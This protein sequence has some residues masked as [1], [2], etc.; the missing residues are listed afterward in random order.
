LLTNSTVQLAVDDQ[1]FTFSTRL[2]GTSGLAAADK[3]ALE[4]A[5]QARFERIAAEGKNQRAFTWGKI[6]F[7]WQTLQPPV[8]NALP[9]EEL[10]P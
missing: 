3:Y 5:G 8:T 7:Q 9:V 6:I 2:L 1:G 4:L 10:L